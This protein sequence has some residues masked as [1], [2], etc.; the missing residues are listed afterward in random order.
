MGRPPKP[1]KLK[2][3]EGNPGN[4]P[5]N[6]NEPEPD[7]GIPE[8][9]PELCARARE[10]WKTRGPGLVAM[11]VLT[12]IDGAVFASYCQAYADWR[13]A[14]ESLQKLLATSPPGNQGGAFLAATGQG[15]LKK[16]P[17]VTVAN[18]AEMRMVKWAAELGMTPAARARLQV[19]PPHETESKLKSLLFKAGS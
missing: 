2:V 17:L 5:L 18:E 11:G 16:S 3:L 19:T 4:R 8:A 9:P 15:G 12:T 10:E 1:T 14:R 13:N 6:E 7:E